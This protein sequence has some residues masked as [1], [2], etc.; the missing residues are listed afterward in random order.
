VPPPKPQHESQHASLGSA[1]THAA[2]GVG[3]K[4]QHAAEQAAEKAMH[5]AQ[6]VGA[7]AVGIVA[8][9]LLV[10]AEGSLD[11]MSGES[12][13]HAMQPPGKPHATSTT[14]RVANTSRDRGW[15]WGPMHAARCSPSDDAPAMRPARPVSET[16]SDPAHCTHP[17][18]AHSDAPKPRCIEPQLLPSSPHPPQPLSMR[19]TAPQVRVLTG[20]RSAARSGRRTGT[21]AGSLSTRGTFT[22]VSGAMIGAACG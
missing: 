4:M 13:Q 20:A 17:K 14:C 3:A 22:R 10:I 2:Q 12:V 6:E 11:G 9:P 21:H 1:L 16:V 8:G 15:G 7:A 5:A 19:L 18:S